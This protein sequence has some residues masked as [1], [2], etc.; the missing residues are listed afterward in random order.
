LATH[1]DLEAAVRAVQRAHPGWQPPA[2]VDFALNSPVGPFIPNFVFDSLRSAAPPGCF[3]ASG[4]IAK[5]PPGGPPPI[6]P[7][8]NAPNFEPPANIPGAPLG[9]PIDRNLTRPQNHI[10]QI[11]A[12]GSHKKNA[13]SVPHD[14][15]H[16]FIDGYNAIIGATGQG[17]ANEGWNKTINEISG[18]LQNALTGLDNAV[19][20]QF[21]NALRLNLSRSLDVLHEIGQHAQTM[22]T[23]FDAFFNDL[24][25]T[26]SNFE[27]Y[28][29]TYN[30]A[31][32][33]P[34]DPNSKE[35]LNQLNEIV[36]D[37]MNV[38]RPPIDDIAS[39]HPSVS[40]AVP[41]VGAPMGGPGGLISGSPGGLGGG[42]PES[43]TR[44][45]LNT[46]KALDPTPSNTA[47]PEG[48]GAQSSP[49]APTGGQNSAED[50]GADKAQKAGGQGGDG[51]PKGPGD[52]LRG[53]GR[54]GSG[55][56]P[57]LLGLG[58]KGLSGSKTGVGSGG[59]GAG[60]GASG[61]GVVGAK[62]PATTATPKLGS[63]AA[64][65]SRAGVSGAGGQGAAGTPVAGQQGGTADKAH[66]ASKALRLPKNGEEVVGEAEAVVPVIGDAPRKATPATPKN[67]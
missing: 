47:K 20:G 49:S 62:P 15:I 1:A 28:A 51:T 55:L 35:T 59:R 56:T 25:T 61:R 11:R 65:M 4:Q 29:P 67:T 27:K 7:R 33:H 16:S 13:K 53:D 38:Y 44:G 12:D 64:P 39:S 17:P 36:L 41:E 24:S 32:E 40:S 19:Q 42:T 60:G 31:I 50:A 23:L 54:G 58:S 34:D 57:G 63:S 2:D 26:K 30:Q 3:D 37:I 48:K 6:L 14:P 45:G 21:A 10:D 43:L 5:P 46:G 66:K 18:L 8:P 9:A 22:E 52:A